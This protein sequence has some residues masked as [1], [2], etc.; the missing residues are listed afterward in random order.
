MRLVTCHQKNIYT[1]LYIVKY[2]VVVTAV[3]KHLDLTTQVC[4]GL[5]WRC[6]TRD[7]TGLVKLFLI[8]GFIFFVCSLQCITLIVIV[9][10]HC[11][12]IM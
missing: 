8:S 3:L 7:N 5:S 6:G 11:T 9:H 12:D 4:N 10:T 2:T 1:L